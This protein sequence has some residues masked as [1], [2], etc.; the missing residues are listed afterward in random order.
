[1]TQFSTGQEIDSETAARLRASVGK[2]SRALRTTQAAGG[3]TPTGI[4][5][6]FTVVRRGPLRMAQLAEIE[7]LN[8]TMLSRIVGGLAERGL[9]R[10]LTDPDDRRAA[11][12]EATGAGR[13]LRTK[14][15]RE[16]DEVI[17]SEL[18]ELDADQRA[19]LLEALPVLEQ[20][21]ETLKE[22]LT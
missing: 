6:L 1:M 22:R 2:L 5:V 18:A 12:V 11:T 14:I 7:S 13:R 21:A 17:A 8:P 19:V 15:H 3:L 10:R 16:R 9:V 4:S 20:L